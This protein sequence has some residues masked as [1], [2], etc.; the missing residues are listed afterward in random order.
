MSGRSGPGWADVANDI[1]DACAREAAWLATT[2]NDGLPVLPVSGGGPWDVV[3]AHW[4]GQKAASQKR[5]IYVCFAANADA[6]PNDLRVRQQHTFNLKIFWAVKI[7]TAGGP[8]A[9]Q[10]ACEA[11][12]QDL[13]GR[14]RG[15]FNDKTHGGRFQSVGEVPKNTG[16]PSVRWQDAEVTIA[17]ERAIRAVITYRADD[18]EVIG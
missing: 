2:T 10:A 11:A 15:P 7:G 6:R 1:S 18:I 17:S 14:I 3:Q 12:V 16:W 8:E 4:P 5:G 13:I 9:E